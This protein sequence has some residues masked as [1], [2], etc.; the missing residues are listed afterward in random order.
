MRKYLSIDRAF[1]KCSLVLS[2]AE[3]AKPCPRP[4]ENSAPFLCPA[5]SANDGLNVSSVRRYWR[6]ISICGYCLRSSEIEGRE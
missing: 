1:A 3:T 2:K 6:M 5:L 4:W